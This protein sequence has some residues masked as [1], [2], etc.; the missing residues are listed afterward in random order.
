[1]SKYC[2]NDFLRV[3]CSSFDDKT[4]QPQS[5]EWVPPDNIECGSFSRLLRDMDLNNPK[6]DWRKTTKKGRFSHKNFG[7][8]LFDIL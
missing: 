1:M 7:A 5:E 3:G 8:Y 4:P 2:I 6:F